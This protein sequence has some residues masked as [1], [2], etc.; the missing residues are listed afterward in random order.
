MVYAVGLRVPAR[1]IA[2]ELD[3]VLVRGE[4]LSLMT[5]QPLTLGYKLMLQDAERMVRALVQTGRGGDRVL[6]G[7]AGQENRDI[8]STGWHDRMWE[9]LTAYGSPNF[10]ELLRYT[11]PRSKCGHRIHA[12]GSANDWEVLRV[13]VAYLPRSQAVIDA[14]EA[15]LGSVVAFGRGAISACNSFPGDGD[16]RFFDAGRDGS[17]P[18]LVTALA[19]LRKKFTWQRLARMTPEDVP[20]AMLRRVLRLQGRFLALGLCRLANGE[21]PTPLLQLEHDRLGFSAWQTLLVTGP[22]SSEAGVHVARDVHVWAGRCTCAASRTRSPCWCILLCRAFVIDDVNVAQ[23]ESSPSSAL[24]VFGL[25]LG[26][27]GLISSCSATAAGTSL[28]SRS[29]SRDMSVLARGESDI[30]GIAEVACSLGEVHGAQV[31]QPQPEQPE[32][33]LASEALAA[34]VD[35]DLGAASGHSGCTA[36]GRG[37][38]NRAPLSLTP[39]RVPSR[40]TDFAEPDT[41]SAVTDAARARADVVSTAGESSHHRAA[42]LPL[43]AAVTAASADAP[44][45]A[46][47]TSSNRAAALI[48]YDGNG[49]TGLFWDRD[50]TW[51]F[52]LEELFN[53][54][55]GRQPLASPTDTAI[56]A[57]CSSRVLLR[58]EPRFR[59]LDARVAAIRAVTSIARQLTLLPHILRLAL[60]RED[61]FSCSNN[62]LAA[63]SNGLQDDATGS[64]TVT[65]IDDLNADAHESMLTSAQ[66]Q[67]IEVPDWLRRP[68]DAV[69][70]AARRIPQTLLE[71]EQPSDALAQEYGMD[72]LAAALQRGLTFADQSAATWVTS[73]E[74]AT[75]NAHRALGIQPPSGQR[76]RGGAAQAIVPAAKSRAEVDAFNAQADHFSS[77]LVVI[78]NADEL[79]NRA[80][81]AAGATRVHTSAHAV[82][83]SAPQHAEAERQAT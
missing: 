62:A 24:S 3:R 47:S 63:G 20:D 83:T 46:A 70:R 38:A 18:Y 5:G 1:V 35:S 11:T 2:P 22:E 32:A 34:A 43:T 77:P 64:D 40:A 61:L 33:T 44:L 19:E 49:V 80:A 6:L 72:G 76:A 74:T 48:P 7:Y 8:K 67:E 10:S 4:N 15:A 29:F 59:A 25:S 79:A 31:H 82:A 78:C 12:F 66:G 21:P 75:A 51:Y 71:H 52:D 13:V 9:H 30:E 45:S 28:G 14:F 36:S 54:V 58:E 39:R 41:G 17:P 42:S 16:R 81:R 27:N 26:T 65:S 55:S 68:L 53:L 60:I 69:A 37:Y 73:L 57:T 23:C 56:P 50:T